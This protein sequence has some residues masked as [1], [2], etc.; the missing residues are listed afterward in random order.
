MFAEHSEI[1]A[2]GGAWPQAESAISAGVREE[3]LSVVNAEAPHSR[4][5]LE[6][7]KRALAR[8]G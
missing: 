6:P 7:N 4:Y 1:G 5:H 2:V 3:L 8:Q